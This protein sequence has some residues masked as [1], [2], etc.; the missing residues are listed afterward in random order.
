MD[1]L[2]SQLLHAKGH[3]AQSAVRP[4]SE[5]YTFQ[6]LYATGEFLRILGVSSTY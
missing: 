1:L 6:L 3:S 4:C 2:M 5:G